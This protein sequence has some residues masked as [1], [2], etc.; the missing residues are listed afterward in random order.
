ML[1]EA[2]LAEQPFYPKQQP[3][4]SQQNIETPKQMNDQKAKSTENTDKGLSHNKNQIPVKDQVQVQSQQNEQ[5]SSIQQQQIVKQQKPPKPK[6][7]ERYTKSSP[8]PQFIPTQFGKQVSTLSQNAQVNEF[9][10]NMSSSPSTNI[11][12][13]GNFASDQSQM[14][15]ISYYFPIKLSIFRMN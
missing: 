1:L 2:I 4:Q 3:Q 8:V 12:D 14:V 11:M 10:Q 6:D 5:I 15:K 7:P 13:L 9:N